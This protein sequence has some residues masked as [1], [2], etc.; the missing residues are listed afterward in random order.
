M[1]SEASIQESILSYLRIIEHTGEIYVVRTGS[2]AIKTRNGSYFRTGRKGCPDITLLYRGKYVG[3]EVKNEV[4]KQTVEQKQAQ[5]AIENAG[6][7]YFIVRSVGEVIDA[8]NKIR[9]N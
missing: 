3:L 8:M 4:G 9:L 6:G 2:G 7:Y 5:Q 1:S